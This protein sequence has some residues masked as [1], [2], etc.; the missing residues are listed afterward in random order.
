MAGEGFSAGGITIG[1]AINERPDLFAVAISRVG[2]LNPLRFETTP[3][4]V[5]NI[6]EFGSCETY[7]GFELLY[8]M[9]AYLHIQ[10]G[11]DYPA[12]MV[13]H[14]ITDTR[15]EPW[16][17]TKFAAR[18]QAASASGKPILLRIDYEGGHGAG[19][20][21]LQRFQERADIFAFMM[22]QFGMEDE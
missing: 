6:P 12:M 13:T 8:E 3:N 1:R 19:S 5:N 7:T 17:S 21:K 15:C 11:V 4:G 18:L 20:T 9:D 10:D 14:G 16:Q 2:C 22:W